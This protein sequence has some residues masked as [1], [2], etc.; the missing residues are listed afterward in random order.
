MGRNLSE[1]LFFFA[2][3]LILGEKWDEIWVKTFFFCSSPDFGRKMGRNLSEDLF[4]SCSLPD[5]RRKKGRNGS[6]TI[7]NSDLCSSQIFWSFCPP[8]PLFKILQNFQNPAKRYRY[9]SES[10][11]L[12]RAWIP[13]IS[14]RPTVLQRSNCSEP[15][16]KLNPQLPHCQVRKHRNAWKSLPSHDWNLKHLMKLPP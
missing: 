12:S 11:T 7:S 5:F 13:T 8:P 15:N 10:L 2:L 6:V 4:F 1:D 14:D 16:S 9:W 3:H